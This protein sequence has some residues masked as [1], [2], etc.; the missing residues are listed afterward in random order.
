MAT[1]SHNLP[2]LKQLCAVAFA[3]SAAA[4]TTSAPGTNASS[5]NTAQ[6]AT[7]NDGEITVSEL[8][9][10]CPG[11]T[12]R[13]GTAFINNYAK[14][15]E[16]TAENLIY[17]AA[18][19]QTTRACQYA[20]GQI[21]MNVAVAGKVVPG[22]KFKPGTVSLPIRVA[23]TRGD[24]V[25]Y[26]KLNTHQVSVT[27]TNSATQFLMNDRTVTFAQPTERNIEIFVGFD[28]GAPKKK[29]SQ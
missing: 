17:Q 14:G 27:S 15:A 6:Q 22:P 26:S 16:E 21:T 5:A 12:V 2:L 11:V 19:M 25:L 10:Y 24:E 20:N 8:R 28:E 1:A 29:A 4:C 18:V 13:E 7:V 3:L 23:A 9:G